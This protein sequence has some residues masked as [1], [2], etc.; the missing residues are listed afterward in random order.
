MAAKDD[1]KKGGGKGWIAAL[2]LVSLVA[3]G[4]GGGLGMYLLS[5]VEKAVD[6]KTKEAESKAVK[7]LKYTGDLALRP[8]GS[9][10]TNLADSGDAWVRLESSVVFKTGAVPNPDIALAE[11]RADIVA[12]L[13][14][15]SMR[16]I[17]GA[18]GL[19]HLREDLNERVALRTK[20]QVRELIVEMLVVQ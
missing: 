4:T 20:G 15:V 14:T 18:S 7:V 5:K 17:E 19:Q 11:I 10:V 3:I 9:V 2:A 8:V 16:Q 6:S 13:R 12:Y 1:T